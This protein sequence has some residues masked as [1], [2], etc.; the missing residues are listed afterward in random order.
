MPRIERGVLESVVQGSFEDLSDNVARLAAERLGEGVEI[1]ATHKGYA[2][3]ASSGSVVRVEW[4][5]KDGE[6]VVTDI[7][8]SDVPVITEDN[9]DRIVSEKIQ[10]VVAKMCGEDYSL[11]DTRNQ[12]HFISSLVKDGGEYW[13]EDLISEATTGFSEEPRWLSEYKENTKSIRSSLHGVLG[14]TE[15]SIPKTRYGRVKHAAL[16][17]FRSE[18]YDSTRIIYEAL[19]QMNGSL[20]GLHFDKEE[21]CGVSLKH[22]RDAIF[23]ESSALVETTKRA[24]RLARP[25][26]LGILA[27]YHDDLAERSREMLVMSRFLSRSSEP[28]TGE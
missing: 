14:S 11:D 19:D 15:S 26:D 20:E 1:I 2:I 7:S 9:E 18:I 17:N 3:A 28:R 24:L 10:E 16:E 12:L 25:S 13:V 21:S 4:D 6:V 22:A 5:I 23:E 27:R 8:K